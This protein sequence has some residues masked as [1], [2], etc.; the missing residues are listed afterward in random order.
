MTCFLIDAEAVQLLANRFN[1]AAEATRLTATATA[2]HLTVAQNA[3]GPVPEPPVF[4]PEMEQIAESWDFAARVLRQRLAAIAAGEIT[5]DELAATDLIA[6][7]RAELVAK[8]DDLVREEIV[9]LVEST[10]PNIV[11]G[12][13]LIKGKKQVPAGQ[14]ETKDV[15]FFYYVDENGRRVEVKIDKKNGTVDTPE[16][17]RPIV[18]TD[19]GRVIMFEGETAL[20]RV[21]ANLEG[22]GDGTTP[23]LET[24]YLRAL[25]ISDPATGDTE[26]NPGVGVG[27]PPLGGGGQR[28]PNDLTAGIDFTARVTFGDANDP[29]AITKEKIFEAIEQILNLPPVEATLDFVAPIAETTIEFIENVA[30]ATAEALGDIRDFFNDLF[31]SFFDPEP[32]RDDDDREGSGGITDAER[33]EF[34][35][36]ASDFSDSNGL[37]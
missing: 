27:S 18:R 8:A 22:R 14:G 26:V 7:L 3:E 19:D 25:G 2:I 24:L 29:D 30:T 6:D 21:I 36:P 23:S 10:E 34:G 17:D 1:L 28:G 31:D 4:R 16:G 15:T 12:A 37:L 5:E 33:T 35:G 9:A 32:P 20:E 13:A 11:R